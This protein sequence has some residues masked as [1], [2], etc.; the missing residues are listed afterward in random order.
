MKAL[1]KIKLLAYMYSTAD[2]MDTFNYRTELFPILL[3]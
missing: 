1:S 2:L 3:L